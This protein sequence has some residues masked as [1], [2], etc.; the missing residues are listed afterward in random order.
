MNC[1][2]CLIEAVQVTRKDSISAGGCL[3]ALI[4]LLALPMLLFDMLIGFVM[5]I[6]A[7]LIGNAGRG[8]HVE[9]V[10]PKC[11]TVVSKIKIK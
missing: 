11:K 3:G 4:F 10:C 6:V 1:P 7:I 5:V 9:L 2:I 8:Q